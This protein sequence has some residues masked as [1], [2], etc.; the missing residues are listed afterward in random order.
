MSIRNFTK[1][2]KI[3][4]IKAYDGSKYVKNANYENLNEFFLIFDDFCNVLC[5]TALKPLDAAKL[6][7]F[8]CSAMTF[9]TVSLH[10]NDK[11]RNRGL[12]CGGITQIEAIS[13]Q[14]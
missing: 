7:C 2:P 4:F 9:E 6:D 8:E 12:R 1:I 5:I 13:T 14:P 11:V 10:V 3:A